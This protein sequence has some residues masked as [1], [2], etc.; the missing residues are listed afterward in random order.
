MVK[1][2]RGVFAGKCKT[3]SLMLKAQPI[4]FI[5]LLLPRG[6][7]PVT[8]VA[9]IRFITVLFIADAAC[10]LSRAGRL[11]DVSSLDIL[12]THLYIHNVRPIL[13]PDVVIASTLFPLIRINARRQP[14][15]GLIR[16]RRTRSTCGG[17]VGT[18]QRRWLVGP[19]R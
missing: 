3:N 2:S 11:Q 17:M 4:F 6:K 1:R 19:P 7:P 12:S 15:Q 8:F 16:A 9:L 10:G 13:A 5:L 18:T 14:S